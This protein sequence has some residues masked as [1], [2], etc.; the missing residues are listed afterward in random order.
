MQPWEVRRGIG[1]VQL[2]VRLAGEHGVSPAACLRGSGI[3]V[4][5][6]DD[7]DAEIEPAQELAVVRNL[8]RHLGHV[9]GIGLEA[10]S[11]YRLTAYGIWGYALL[12]SRTLRSASEFGIRYLDLTFAF[13]RF[14]TD[15]STRDLRVVLDDSSIPEDCRQFLLERDAAASVAVQRDLFQRPVPLQRV[16]FRFPRPRYAERFS[17]LF[18]GPVSFGEPE[19]SITIAPNWADQPLPQANERT[20]RFCEEQ[21]QELLTRR[22]ARSHVSERVRQ[23][24]L[25]PSR[26]NDME[27]VAAELGMAPRTLRRR[28]AAEGTSF[29]RLLDEVRE[30]LAEEMLTHRM[31]VEEVAE[32]LGYAEASSF[33]HAFKRWKG[34]PPGLYRD[35]EAPNHEREA[36]LHG[37]DAQVHEHEARR[38]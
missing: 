19:N 36:Q 3:R 16:T 29:R 31:T 6:L 17:E 5:S 2:L 7:P 35:R 15:R 14:R 30:T 37:R 18:P 38:D 11:R 20:A 28:L 23:Y 32:R 1:S 4:D 9:P 22:R 27:G 10:G 33:V 24:L 34:V 13:V 21:C 12:S 25:R 26:G 8:V